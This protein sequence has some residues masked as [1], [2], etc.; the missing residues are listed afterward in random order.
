MRVKVLT[1]FPE[2]FPG[3]LGASLTGRAL[4]EGKWSLEAVN[5]RDYAFDK[6]ASV[7]DTPSGGGAGMVMRADFWGRRSTTTIAAEGF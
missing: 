7:D 2:L 3:F 1:I 6:H 5:I 4:D